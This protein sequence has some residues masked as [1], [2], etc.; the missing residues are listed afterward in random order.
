VQLAALAPH[1]VDRLGERHPV[2][3]GV[4]AEGG[5][6][7][8]AGMGY[9]GA[10]APV[11]SVAAT[12]WTHQW[13]AGPDGNVNNWWYADDV[14][15]PTKA[16]DFYI[17]DFSS[18]QK[19]GQQLDVAAPGSWT[20]GP[21]QVNSGQL[22]YYYLSGTSMATPHVTGIVALM[23]Q[24]KPSLTAAAA[25]SI[26]K[27]TAIALPPGSRTVALPDGTTEVQSW[28]S[29]ATGSGMVTADAAL[30]GIK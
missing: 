27:S 17:A 22:S 10:Y 26:L 2:E 3:P 20:V 18:R 11:I 9:P 4:L 15:D 16:A 7:G 23:C 21:Y 19:A 28:G 14:A 30:K 25:E 8:N 1:L 5:N 29:D 13:L 6:E 12:G 24:K